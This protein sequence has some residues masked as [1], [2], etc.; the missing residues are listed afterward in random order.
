MEALLVAFQQVLQPQVLLYLILGTVLGLAVGT[1]P[2]LT[3]TM[4]VAILTPLTFWLPPESGLGVLIGVWNA[5]IFAGGISAV[6]LNI[7]GTPASIASTFDGHPLVKKDQAG[8]ALGINVLYSAIGGLF[9]ILIFLIAAF[10]LARFALSF[11]PAEYFALGLFGLSMMIAVSGTSVVKGL[12]AGFIGLALSLVGLD[13]MLAT[14]RF[15]LGSTQLITG[16]SFIPLMIGIF[17]LGEVFYQMVTTL[18]QPQEQT[19]P[20]GERK[21]FSS[22]GRMLVNAKE[23]V[24]TLPATIIGSVTG[25]VIGAIPGSGADIASLIGWE[26]S[27]R[28]S[29]RKEEYG[30]G[31]IEGLAATCTAN[32]SCLGGALTTMMALGIPGDAVTAVLIGSFMMYG[33]QPGP[34]MFRDKSDFVFMVIGLMILAN[35]FFLATGFIFSR[36]AGGF[37]L[38]PKPI[39][40][41][42][43]LILSLVGSFSLNNRLFDVWVAFLGGILGFLFRRYQFPLGP[44]ILALILGPIVERNFRTALIISHGNPAIFLTRPISLIFI[45][46][47]ALAL[48]SPL[49]LRKKRGQKE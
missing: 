3:A 12:I 16:L 9:G 21:G 47:T 18:G 7:P 41:S 37:I 15:N 1:L 4:A 11:G 29:K 36:F 24:Q 20:Q 39:M 23:F 49:F 5:S 22:L 40:W 26:F 2:G 43:I 8:L 46:G 25:V 38:L 6:L 14:P 19:K 45:L 17:G 27:R 30:K 35:L 32:N 34:A 10:P 31:S 42:T 44:I 13:P 28:T 33:V 48:A